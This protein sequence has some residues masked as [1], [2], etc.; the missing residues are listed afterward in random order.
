[1]ETNQ[2]EMLRQIIRFSHATF[3]N[4]YYATAMMQDQLEQ[5]AYI[6]L[7][8]TP[9]LTVHGRK[10]IESWADAYKSGR[11]SFKSFVDGNFMYLEKVF[12]A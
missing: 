9:W 2:K 10:T 6:A 4:T 3:E 11:E 5:A 1:M 12:V 7:D 8:Q